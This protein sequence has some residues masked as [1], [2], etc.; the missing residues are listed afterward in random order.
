MNY[1]TNDIEKGTIQ[2]KYQIGTLTL[3]IHTK[4]NFSWIKLN[5]NLKCPLRNALI[6]LE[7]CKYFLNN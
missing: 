6:I 3:Y 2:R 4:I 1:F 7:I 5:L